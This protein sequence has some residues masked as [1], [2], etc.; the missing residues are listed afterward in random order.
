MESVLLGTEVDLYVDSMKCSDIENIGQK[1]YVYLLLFA[2]F[3][4]VHFLVGLN[5]T[6]D[7]P[8]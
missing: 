3:N 5:G 2:Y 8:N 6:V 1:T 7:F 4:L